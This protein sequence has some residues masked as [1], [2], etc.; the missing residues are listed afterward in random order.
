MMS[1]LISPRNG[2]VLPDPSHA[3]ATSTRKIPPAPRE[4]DRDDRVLVALEHKLGL[5]GGNVAE[6]NG[7]VFGTGDDP[8]A[9]RRNGDGE[10][11]V[12]FKC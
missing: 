5:P 2:L 6:L 3:I 8:L 9:V 1:S 7:T 11:I 12:L 10:D 4:I